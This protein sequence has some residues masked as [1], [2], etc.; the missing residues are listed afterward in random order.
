MIATINKLLLAGKK[1][2]SEMHLR[3]PGFTYRACGTFRKYKERTKKILKTGDL[4]NIYEKELDKVCFQYYMAS[5]DFKDLI[6]RTA[7]DKVLRNKACNIA[8]NPK[9]YGYQRIITL[10]V[11]TFVNEKFQVEPLRLETNLQLKKIL[12]EK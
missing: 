5:G 11:Y 10:M 7:A 6:R 3:K 12:I 1:S 4:R 2:L 8:K 9:C